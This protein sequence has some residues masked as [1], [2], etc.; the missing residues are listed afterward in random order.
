MLLSEALGCKMREINKGNFSTFFRHTVHKVTQKMSSVSD[1]IH[2][3]FR[4]Q[5][6]MHEECMTKITGR[7]L[8]MFNLSCSMPTFTLFPLTP[9]Q[10]T[11]H[12]T[13]Q[14]MVLQERGS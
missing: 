13:S 10:D 3:M 12:R 4:S 8:S 11:Q 6:E 5:T 9:L 2:G 7:L 14:Q 1:V